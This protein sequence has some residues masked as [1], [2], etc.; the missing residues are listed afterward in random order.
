MPPEEGRGWGPGHSGLRSGL[1]VRR[2][3]SKY[4][5]K[6]VAKNS[7]NE[8][9]RRMGG[10]ERELRAKEGFFSADSLISTLKHGQKNLVE[11]LG[12]GRTLRRRKGKQEG[13]A[14]ERPV[15]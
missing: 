4:S 7:G 11:G 13:E 6:R 14:S 9:D 1:A 2:L 8:K 15:P 10:R 3:N 12:K 5:F